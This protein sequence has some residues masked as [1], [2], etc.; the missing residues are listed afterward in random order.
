MGRTTQG[1]GVNNHGRILEN[2]CKRNSEIDKSTHID[3]EAN[4][5]CE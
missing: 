1:R 3:G 4:A 5:V 2:R